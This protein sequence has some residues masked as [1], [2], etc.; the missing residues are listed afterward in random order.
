M[1]QVKASNLL[2]ISSD[3]VDC[4]LN[5]ARTRWNLGSFWRRFTGL[6]FLTP[7]N[8]S[9]WMHVQLLVLC[10]SPGCSQ[11]QALVCWSGTCY[12]QTLCQSKL[13]M[14]ELWHD[15]TEW[16]TRHCLDCVHEHFRSLAHEHTCSIKLPLSQS[17]PYLNTV[18]LALE[19]WCV[20][21]GL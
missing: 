18:M 4:S 17:L 13:Y 7:L 12:Y 5:L 20:V 9:E 3:T 11:L 15:A 14:A 16:R 21:A 8:R 1:V 10:S 19:L 6:I 2:T